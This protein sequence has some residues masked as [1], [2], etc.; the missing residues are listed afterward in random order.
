[1]QKQFLLLWHNTKKINKLRISLD[2]RNLNRE[3]N[4]SHYLLPTVEVIKTKRS[5]TQ[6]FYILDANLE[7]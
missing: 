5:G 4:K 1:M 3:I 2:P 6:F 7:L